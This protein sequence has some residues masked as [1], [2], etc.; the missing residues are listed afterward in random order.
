[1]GAVFAVEDD[2]LG[3]RPTT[4]IGGTDVA[5]GIRWVGLDVHARESTI[6]VF[7]QSKPL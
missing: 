6:A 5:D 3:A 4:Y 7:D 2:A 1:V